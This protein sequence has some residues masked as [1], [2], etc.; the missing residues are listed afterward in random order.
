MRWL[1]A[2]VLL[3]L[4]QS[5]SWAQNVEQAPTT[6]EKGTYL[7]VLLSPVPEVLYDHVPELPRGQGVVVTHVLPESPAAQAQLRRHDILLLYDDA[8][9]QGCEHFARLIR[10]D[11]PERSVKLTL[12]RGGKRMS[13]DVTLTLG[14]VLKI[15]QA[16]RPAPHE[17]A[18]VPRGTAKAGSPPAV[19]VGAVPLDGGRMKVTVE[20]YAEGTGRLQSV[21]YEGT[22]DEIQG[23]VQKLPAGVQN[24]TQVA[25]RRIRALEFQSQDRRAGSPDGTERR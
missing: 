10:A 15:A 7:G 17:T 6:E 1:L 25:L 14:P 5:W 18:E 12:L 21:A 9:I 16:N 23:E 2:V 24:L 13:A 20:Y 8:K 4:G 22:L 19:S 3:A 11:K